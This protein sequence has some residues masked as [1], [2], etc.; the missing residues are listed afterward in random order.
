MGTGR[1]TGLIAQEA[2][3]LIPQYV[4]KPESPDEMWT[5]FYNYLVPVLI[6]AIQELDTKV[7][8]LNANPRYRPPTMPLMHTTEELDGERRS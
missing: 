3:E 4:N 2:Y 7:E 8:K 6:K 1:M 5:V